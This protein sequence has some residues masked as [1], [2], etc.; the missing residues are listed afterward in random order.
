MPDF[1]RHHSYAIYEFSCLNDATIGRIQDD[2]AQLRVLRNS[3]PIGDSSSFFTAKSSKGTSVIQIPHP[4]D[5]RLCE[6][7]CSVFDAIVVRNY[8]KSDSNAG[9]GV[10]SNFVCKSTFRIPVS[11]RHEDS[12]FQTLINSLQDWMDCQIS[13][14]DS[15]RMSSKS[16]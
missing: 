15:P 1:N 11:E 9:E 14:C 10:E 6:Y 3:A 5:Q 13:S 7:P 4:K 16:R 8:M 12:A 2:L